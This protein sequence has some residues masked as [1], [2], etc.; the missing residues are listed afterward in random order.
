MGSSNE[1]AVSSAETV[2]NEIPASPMTSASDSEIPPTLTRSAQPSTATPPLP[3]LLTTAMASSPTTQSRNVSFADDDVAA[4]GGAVSRPESGLFADEVDLGDASSTE[5]LDLDDP[6]GERSRVLSAIQKAQAIEGWAESMAGVFVTPASTSRHR[7]TPC[8]DGNLDRTGL[9]GFEPALEGK[10]LVDKRLA[11]Q[12]PVS[13]RPKS[14]MHDAQ[15]NATSRLRPGSAP[16]TVPRLV[17]K[18]PMAA[19]GLWKEVPAHPV[20]NEL[21][22]ELQ[23]KNYIAMNLLKAREKRA[24]EAKLA[25][26]MALEASANLA[27]QAIAQARAIADT[28]AQ[29]AAQY[30][31]SLRPQSA[32]SGSR[33]TSRSRPGSSAA[34]A[35]SAAAAINGSRLLSRAQSASN[36]N[37][38]SRPKRNA[39]ALWDLV[40]RAYRTTISTIG[41][42]SNNA[43]VKTAQPI[44]YSMSLRH[45]FQ[46]KYSLRYRQQQVL[47]AGCHIKVPI[48]FADGRVAASEGDDARRDRK[49]DDWSTTAPVSSYTFVTI[50]RTRT[51]TIWDVAANG[52]P[53]P[54][55]PRAVV[56]CPMEI[57]QMAFVS[58]LCVY[59]GVGCGRGLKFFNSRLEL[60][61]ICRT[62]EP[63]LFVKYNKTAG[64]L[65]TAGS[66]DICVWKLDGVKLRRRHHISFRIIATLKHA[67]T[68]E[69]PRDEWIS[70]IYV[71]EYTSRVFCVVGTKILVHDLHY[72]ACLPMLRNI[73]TRHV[74]TLIQHDLYQYTIIGFADGSIQ[75]RNMAHSIIHEF[76]SHTQG[77]TALALY[78][79]GH[80]LVSAA[81]DSTIRMFDLKTFNEVYCLH[82]RDKPLGLSI[83]DDQLLYIRVSYGVQVW[84]LNHVN[85]SFAN[86]SSKVTTLFR[87]KSHNVPA[88]LVTRTEDGVIRLLSP[89]SG[90]PVT[91]ALPLLE[92]DSVTDIAYCAKID[93][94]YLMLESGEIWVVATNANPC[95][96]VDIWR[97]AE[98][99]REDVDH[100]E[101]FDGR[102][103]PTDEVPSG[104]DRA[105][106]FAA[107]L[108]T[109]R[110][111]QVLV[112][113]KRGGVGD[114][115]QLHSSEITQILC[116]QKQQIL[117]TCGADEMIKISM[118]VPTCN[119]T[120]LLQQKIA[121]STHMVPKTMAVA[122]GIVCA[123]SDDFAIQM[124]SF[125]IETK[126]WR[127]LASHNRSDDHTD[128][129]T[130]ICP[131][132]KLRLFVSCSRDG[133]IRVWDS[134]NVLIREIQFNEPL[135]HVC[136]GSSYGNLLFGF[137]SRLDLIKYMSYLPPTYAQ[138]AQKLDTTVPKAEPPVPFDD[139]RTNW[140]SLQY[141]APK[142]LAMSAHG[143]Q[144]KLF[145]D[146]NL[147]GTER[148]QDTATPAGD[149]KDEADTIDAEEAEYEQLMLRINAM[150]LQRQQFVEAA[151]RKMEAEK[152]DAARQEEIMHEQVRNFNMMNRFRGHS[153]TLFEGGEIPVDFRP[154]SPD[155]VVVADDKTADGGLADSNDESDGGEGDDEYE[156]MSGPN[157]LVIA[158]EILARYTKELAKQK[159]TSGTQEI[160][161]NAEAIA[162]DKSVEAVKVRRT[163]SKRRLHKEPQPIVAAPDADALPTQL[164]ATDYAAFERKQRATRIRMRELKRLEFLGQ[165]APTP[166]AAAAEKAEL[167]R[168]ASP[169]TKR[170]KARETAPRIPAP[171]G[172]LPNSFVQH[173]VSEWKKT[174]AGFHIEDLALKAKARVIKVE[175]SVA[176][177]DGKRKQRS[178]D[179]KAKLKEMLERMPEPEP[180]VPPE[181]QEA[182]A[183][184]TEAAGAAQADADVPPE[185]PKLRVPVRKMKVEALAPLEPV[186]KGPVTIVLPPTIEKLATY[187]W[188]P[189]DEIFNPPES[190]PEPLAKTGRRASTRQSATRKSVV[191]APTTRTVKLEKTDASALLPVVLNA[192]RSATS[193]ETRLEV[194]D[195][196]HWLNEKEPI[197]DF[198]NI[199]KIMCKHLVTPVAH[200][201]GTEE[202]GQEVQ[203][204]C[205]LIESIAKFAPSHL[206]VVPALLV[207]T[208]SAHGQIRS[209]ATQFLK[210]L[211]VYAPENKFVSEAVRE[212]VAEVSPEL[213]TELR[214]SESSRPSSARPSLSRPSSSSK[215]R[216]RPTP[217]AK[218]KASAGTPPLDVKTA[219]TNF[220]KKSLKSYLIRATPSQEIRQH[221]KGMTIHGFEIKG[222]KGGAKPE[223]GA[224]DSERG[225][226]S[227]LKQKGSRASSASTRPRSGGSAKE[228]K[229]VVFDTDL[230]STQEAAPHEEGQAAG[231]D[232]SKVAAPPVAAVGLASAMRVAVPDFEMD[233]SMLMESITYRPSIPRA[234]DDSP[235]V[236]PS[237]GARSFQQVLVQ[238]VQQQQEVQR[239]ASAHRSPVTIL[240]NPTTADYVS[241]LNFFML[242]LQHQELKAE[243]EAVAA[244]Q[245]QQDVAVERAKEEEKKKMKAEAFV[246]KERERVEKL[247][248]RKKQITE[249]KKDKKGQDLAGA[250]LGEKKGKT[251]AEM[252]TKGIGLT[253]KSTCHPSR[254]TLDYDQSKFPSLG[255]HIHGRGGGVYADLAM[256]IGKYN[257]SMPMERVSLLPFD[258]G[259]AGS[260]SNLYNS[261]SLR[262]P[263]S[264]SRPPTSVPLGSPLTPAQLV[265][266]WQEFSVDDLTAEVLERELIGVVP[267]AE[268]RYIR[269]AGIGRRKQQNARLSFD[270]GGVGEDG[271]AAPDEERK[272]RTQ[273]K[274]FI[275]ALSVALET[276]AAG[277]TLG[278]ID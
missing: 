159:K 99:A 217:A 183:D 112:Y 28:I 255:A 80:V 203:L 222:K 118:V 35:A 194:V 64:E 27:P 72:Y 142:K 122:D 19:S 191:A 25:P 202:A 184:V 182:V 1:D 2:S 137:Q 190:S 176:S 8:A 179:Y 140:K 173:N 78:P 95:I 234:E 136:V 274:Y 172:V 14:L 160:A 265:P 84:S 220:L 170:H 132:R 244:L 270:N 11:G 48:H 38:T 96:V 130:T 24:A 88:R 91:T 45:G 23:D 252:Q 18:V 47:W 151:R 39:A 113:G 36:S 62:Q 145:Q 59:V 161:L 55:K 126:G 89:A 58:K 127:M 74:K 254:E 163:K 9:G 44:P 167:V 206:D 245:R 276:V 247:E 129:V 232:A 143:D 180:E 257:R 174:H 256:H 277:Q 66:H 63:V 104:Y 148:S 13:A 187:D 181:G 204:R 117:L 258:S 31:P 50:D 266:S 90:K 15:S 128:L 57:E 43:L 119:A 52:A 221:L 185:I 165:G 144:W 230:T 67:Y 229:K 77:I 271:P 242:D 150:A 54:H 146:V 239:A 267:G 108:G 224:S 223:E 268:L 216:E 86:T 53:G 97:M 201:G 218:T 214:A 135:R 101:I 87:A 233:M 273:R 70:E 196:I 236:I 37:S 227:V 60:L 152:A 114:R 213:G 105:S 16:A 235:T 92:T 65:V 215:L 263:F 253:H 107:L 169:I 154:T 79:H 259:A 177:D 171:D 269:S 192:F 156:S 200:E 26:Q 3:T 134:N 73:S 83:M 226:K 211:G 4:A 116:D 71:D 10:R 12:R 125:D 157:G 275:P 138:A 208:L 17:S 133:S 210:A 121:I 21:P 164:S 158:A 111:G 243:Q 205:T 102:F 186:Q 5:G 139:I 188:C 40:R 120:A 6:D 153:G 199:L 250:S 168:P 189:V 76:N 251:I 240:Q 115:S 93:R 231:H 193:A 61:Q 106:G 178:E 241:G 264:A 49:A 7:N 30:D 212:L 260:S 29:V 20:H 237:A 195:Y 42:E 272:F 197:P 141:R 124:Y 278:F 32:R 46:Y 109:T 219:V 34:A 175:D 166:D 68:T 69:L 103:S 238:S 248:A 228:K 225:P 209:R 75:I 82:L 81:L 131:I 149:D 94:M 261:R 147:V 22:L 162:A 56:K 51:A 41:A 98:S 123:S 249:A 110:N 33:G 198:N 207:Q 85:Q 100:I 155:P 262:P 246:R